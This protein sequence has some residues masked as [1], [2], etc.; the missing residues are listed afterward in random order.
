MRDEA[1]DRA[2]GKRTLVVLMGSNMAKYYHYYLVVL[3]MLG[4][5]SFSVLRLQ[6]RWQLLY[7][8]AFL[9]LTIHLLIVKKNT[10]PPALDG[11][12]KVVALSTFAM[13]VLF[14]I[15]LL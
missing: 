6:M 4:M 7:I 5:L 12:L 15:G 11:Q 3:A 9:P 8:L 14:F 2:A 1:N 10:N 13:A